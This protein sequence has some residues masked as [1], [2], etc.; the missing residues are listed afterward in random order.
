MRRSRRTFLFSLSQT[1]FTSFLFPGQSRNPCPSHWPTERE[2]TWPTS[3]SL[4]P[5]PLRS[6]LPTPRSL[7]VQWSTRG[8][9]DTSV[10]RRVSTSSCA[11]PW[12][13]HVGSR[14]RWT[15]ETGGIVSSWTPHQQVLVLVSKWWFD[16]Q[17]VCFGICQPPSCSQSW[18]K[19]FAVHLT[20]YAFGPI[21]LFLIGVIGSRRR[22]RRSWRGSC[23][24]HSP[25]SNVTTEKELWS[26]SRSTSHNLFHF[27]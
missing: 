3:V 19:K 26:S 10:W 2:K 24:C 6:P 18:M 8:C 25:R 21:A 1:V 11:S 9:R 5:S 12:S 17:R 7:T 4:P 27:I 13:C 20:K 22:K 14:R 23:S 16:I 15:G